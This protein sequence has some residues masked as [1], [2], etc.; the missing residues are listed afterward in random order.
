MG[1]GEK[2]SSVAT[3]VSVVIV[4]TATVAGVFG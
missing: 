2:R 1:M 3:L 4:L